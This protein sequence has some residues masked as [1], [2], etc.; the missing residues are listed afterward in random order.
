MTEETI[1]WILSFESGRKWYNSLTSEGT[2]KLYAGKFKL[3]CDAVGKN[4]DEL[5][6]LK[7]KLIELVVLAKSDKTG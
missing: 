3:Y 1:P 2:K 5:L 7:P 6:K 4:P